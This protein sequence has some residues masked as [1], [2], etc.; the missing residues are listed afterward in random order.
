MVVAPACHAPLDCSVWAAHAMPELPL[1][2][3][4]NS[5]A[6]LG[7][8]TRTT[9]YKPVKVVDELL[10]KSIAVTDSGYHSCGLDIK[11]EV[12]C[13]GNNENFLGKGF[14]FLGPT[15]VAPGVSFSSMALG[16]THICGIETA[17]GK[18]LCW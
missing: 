5:S 18:T 10:F 1:I 16:K 6:Q 3:G 13:W 14:D 15:Q 8:G 9:R 11:G 2:P 4:E 7:D 17:T 12:W